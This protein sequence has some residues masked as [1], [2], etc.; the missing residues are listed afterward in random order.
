MTAVIDKVR[1]NRGL[2]QSPVELS[3]FEYPTVNWKYASLEYVLKHRSTNETLRYIISQCPI[4]KQHKRV[5]I[6]VKVQNLVPSKTSCIPGWHLDGPENPLHPSRPEVHHLYI[7]EKGGETEFIADSFELGIDGGMKQHEIV[8]MIPENVSVTKSVA[9]C[10]TSFT[11]FDFHRGINVKKP[12]K[13][14]LIRLTETD[15]ILPRN[16][17]YLGAVGSVD[18]SSESV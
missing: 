8:K 7:H 5:L 1:F 18:I 6:D 11:R 14:L 2:V 10:F 3:D 16:K 12:M 17:P 15:L 9:G 13:R 4:R